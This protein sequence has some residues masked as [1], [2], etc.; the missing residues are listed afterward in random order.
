ME[1]SRKESQEGDGSR[2]LQ[3]STG[4]FAERHRAR[5]SP[6]VREADRR[7]EDMGNVLT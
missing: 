4:G 6:E 3:R 1:Q 7:L 5:T 2:T